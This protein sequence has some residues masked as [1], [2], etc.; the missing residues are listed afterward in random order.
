MVGGF[1]Q[2]WLVALGSL[3]AVG[4][5][6]APWDGPRP[7]IRTCPRAGRGVVG[8]RGRREACSA[9]AG[10]SRHCSGCLARL[11]PSCVPPWIP[12]YNQKMNT[13]PGIL[14]PFL[15]GGV[16]NTLERIFWLMKKKNPSYFSANLGS[17][18]YE[19]IIT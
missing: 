13:D 4:T 3:G 17:S 16:V 10:G 8:R 19:F 1:S 18:R 6:W 11:Q 15:S 2:V 14:Y 12:I 7:F 9:P 5:G